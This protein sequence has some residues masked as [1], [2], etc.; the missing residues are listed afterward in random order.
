[1]IVWGA[2]CCSGGHDHGTIFAVFVLL[3]IFVLLSYALH[4]ISFS[5][6]P[7]VFNDKLELS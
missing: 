4:S 1:M 2:Q 7:T 3:I 5:L 6:S